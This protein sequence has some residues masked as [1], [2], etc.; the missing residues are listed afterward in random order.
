MQTYIENNFLQPKED[1]EPPWTSWKPRPDLSRLITIE[2]LHFSNGFDETIVKIE[3]GNFQN[4]YN[5]VK[6]DLSSLCNLKEIESC[7][8]QNAWKL[9]KII[10]PPSLEIISFGTFDCCTRLVQLDLSNLS[11][12]KN[13][14]G[15]LFKNSYSLQEIIFPPGIKKINNDSFKNCTSLTK[16]DF[17]NYEQLEEIGYDTF[18][19]AWSLQEIIFPRNL[20]EISAGAFLNCTS[21]TRL[22]FSHCAQFEEFGNNIFTDAFS[23]EEIVFPPT[24]QKITHHSFR[25]CISLVRLQIPASVN[26]IEKEAFSGCTNLEEVVFENPAGISIHE[27]AFQNCPRLARLPLR[28]KRYS[29]FRYGKYSELKASLQFGQGSEGGTCGISLEEFQDDSE[30]V[31]L[32]CGHAYLEE[33]FNEWTKRQRICPTCKVGLKL[34]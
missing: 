27:R 1:I 6:L 5:L 2:P 17:S 34:E 30:I 3:F 11:N 19:S 20:R 14:Q 15:F 12:L 4:C 24:L 28:P 9:Q 16:L 7:A 18:V 10:F 23:L 22:D 31:V 26:K 29:G 25:N 32:P 8:F 33:A 21:L 13:I